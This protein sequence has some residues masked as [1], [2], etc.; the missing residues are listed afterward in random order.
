MLLLLLLLLQQTWAAA[1]TSVACASCLMMLCQGVQS[2]CSA[3]R[4]HLCRFCLCL[5]TRQRG[6]HGPAAHGTPCN[7][8]GSKCG[9]TN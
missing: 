4:V 1:T 2:A 5:Q 8:S 3:Q 7:S 6:A 9:L